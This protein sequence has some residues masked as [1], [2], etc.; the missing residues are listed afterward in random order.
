M[1]VQTFNELPG[2]NRRFPSKGEARKMVQGSW[3]SVNRSKIDNLQFNIDGS[4]LL[5]DE[6]TCWYRKTKELLPGKAV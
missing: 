6:I 2:R 4:L 3:V 1:Q 5:P